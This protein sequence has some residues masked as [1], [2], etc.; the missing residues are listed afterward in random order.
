MIKDSVDME[1]KALEDARTIPM[2]L[3]MNTDMA[4]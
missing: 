3:E 2:M 1:N 4:I